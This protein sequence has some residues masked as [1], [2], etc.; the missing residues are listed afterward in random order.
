MSKRAEKEWF[1]WLDQI[2]AEQVDGKLKTIEL[3]AEVEEDLSLDIMKRIKNRTWNKLGMTPNPMPA[4]DMADKPTNKLVKIVAYHKNK[5]ERK[6]TR[7]T[8]GNRKWL[9]STVAAAALVVC[10][11]FVSV[12][13]DVKAHVQKMLQYIPGYGA[14]IDTESLQQTVRFVLPQ[15]VEKSFGGGKLEVRGISILEKEASV[16]LVGTGLKEITSFELR[17]TKGDRYPFHWVG[18]LGRD[19]AWNGDYNYK[20]SIDVT[21]SMELV[22]GELTIPISLASPNEAQHMED[23]GETIEHNEIQ[24]TVVSNESQG[25]DRKVTIVPR[26]P[27]GTKI[28]SFGI[29]S[30][31]RN[32]PVKLT[33]D[34]GHP[35]NY[36]QDANY[37]NPN[38]FYYKHTDIKHPYKLLLPE[39]LLERKFDKPV[40]ITVPIP[41][42]GTISLRQKIDL[43]GYPLLINEVER[44]DP[45]DGL[46][47]E[48]QNSINLYF[49]FLY[50][51]HASESLLN[52]FPAFTYHTGAAWD[53]DEETNAAKYMQ[54]AFKPGAKTFDLYVDTIRTVVRGP[55]EFTLE[56]K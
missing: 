48:Q 10:I 6:L 14:I 43:F 53:Y 49:D 9:S 18:I 1:D 54:I 44:V 41:E 12:S 31:R 42:K 8:Y 46:D 11:L 20:G 25:G 39:V 13:P 3:S 28:I 27:A 16:S 38:E 15:P 50:K 55:W 47:R 4:L 21:A 33:D 22:A 24:L 52:L 32:F 7:D 37:P 34:Q 30:H 56:N 36:T 29:D 26:I 35:V 40:K 51:D 2:D 17:N 23:L 19:P 5:N 45:G